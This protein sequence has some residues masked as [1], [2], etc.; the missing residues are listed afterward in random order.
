M[1]EKIKVLYIDDEPANLIGFKAALR[2]DCDVF[3]TTDTSEAKDILNS[4]PDI[5]I[6]FCDQRMPVQ[7]GVQFF[8]EIRNSYPLPV[9]ILLTGYTDIEA[10][11]DA[12]NKS[13]VFRFVKKPW[14]YEDILS[15]VNESNNFY[16][17]NSMLAEKNAGL[18][19]AY[20]ELDKFAYSVSH[21]IRGP[22]SG[23]LGAINIASDTNNIAEIRETLGLMEKSVRKLDTFIKGMHDYYS[24][25][26]GELQ[27]TE[28][29]FHKLKEDIIDIYNVYSN[30]NHIRFEILTDI[31]EAFR[32]DK[33]LLETIINNLLSN[34]FKYQRKDAKDKMIELS[35][36]VARTTATIIVKDNGVGIQEKYIGDIF[37]LFFRA[38][39][40]EAGSGF[41]LYN[42]KDALIKLNGTIHVES[43]VNV[44]TTF[45]VMIPNK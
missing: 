29:D 41:G 21:D 8:E 32:S 1:S 28:I 31:A 35:I 38:S 20:S 10:V 15:A 3:T 39:S 33:V 40:L 43:K 37:N 12:I 19:K 11:I 14:V 44:G 25:Q 13:N 26:R 36:K 9:R 30:T 4:N 6:I 5:R 45:T 23:I 16:I 24:L 34:A 22:L 42:V 7:T 18:Q 2:F 17:A 27:I